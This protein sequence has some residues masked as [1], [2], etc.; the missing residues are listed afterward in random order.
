MKL[1]F[2]TNTALTKFDRRV[3]KNIAII[4]CFICVYSCSFIKKRV[5]DRCMKYQE[6]FECNLSGQSKIHPCIELDKCMRKNW[7]GKSI[8]EIHNHRIWMSRP[9]FRIIAIWVLNVAV[10]DTELRRAG[11]IYSL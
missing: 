10:T 8:E 6:I 1:N 7:I 11:N 9:G 3:L 2:H 4:L 5:Y